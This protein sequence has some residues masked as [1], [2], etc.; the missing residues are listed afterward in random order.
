[1]PGVVVVRTAYHVL[2]LVAPENEEDVYLPKVPSPSGQQYIYT[3]QCHARLG[4]I[5]IREEMVCSRVT[6]AAAVAVV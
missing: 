5:S 1:M 4:T 2:F 3:L 6:H